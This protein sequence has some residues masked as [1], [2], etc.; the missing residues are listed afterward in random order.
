M[1]TSEKI[2]LVSKKIDY[3]EIGQAVETEAYT[4]PFA[5]IRSASAREVDQAEDGMQREYVFDVR[6]N[7]YKS[8]DE[9]EYN[10]VRYS[11]YRPY[12]NDSKGVYELYTQ[13][14][15]GS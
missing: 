15:V 3:D 7:D 9:L 8:E 10:G 5:W 6:I 13:R 2:T 1:N 12:L 11:I 4:Y 14:R